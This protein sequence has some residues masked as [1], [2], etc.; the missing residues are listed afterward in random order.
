[1]D[2]E[3]QENELVALESI[4]D[5]IFFKNTG[6]SSG[7]IKIEPFL[8]QPSI[9]VISPSYETQEVSEN[10]PNKSTPEIH[11]VQFLPPIVL[12]FV[13]PPTYPSESPPLYVLSSAW[14]SKSQV[15][16]SIDSTIYL[17]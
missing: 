10:T 4:L 12:S 2:L 9:K 14:L 11:E 3:E 7:E 13:L 15:N 17:K 6:N 1:M 5:P 16:I 8:K